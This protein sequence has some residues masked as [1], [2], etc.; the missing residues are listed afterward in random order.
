VPSLTSSFLA[1]SLLFSRISEQVLIPF[2]LYGF[3]EIGVG[4][5]ALVVPALIK[6]MDGFYPSL[7]LT[8]GGSSIL[9]FLLD[10]W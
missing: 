10:A 4:L 6:V 9:F 5:S 2:R 7:Y 1:I 3:L 8:L